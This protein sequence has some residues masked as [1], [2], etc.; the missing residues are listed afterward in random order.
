MASPYIALY[1]SDFLADIGHLGNTELGI[2]WRLLLVYYRDGRPLPFDTDRLRRLAMTFSPEE[3]RALEQVVAEFF[4]LSTEPDGSRVWRHKRA[5]TEIERAT[6][7]IDAKR[8]GAEKARAKLAE[9]RANPLISEQTSALASELISRG[10]PE[11]EPEPT[12]NTHPTGVRAPAIAESPDCPHRQVLEL[13]KSILPSMP[14]HDPELWSG[15]RAVNLRTRWRE[16]AKAKGWTDVQQG[17]AWFERLFRYIALSAFLTGR[18]SVSD[19]R[20]FLIELEWLVK[21]ANWVKVREGKYH[22]PD[23]VPHD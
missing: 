3:C 22:Q 5:D 19:K 8:S 23:E 12:L 14:Q 7:Y 20:P 9:K 21:H 15:T 17:L 2:Y 18:A 6:K 13:W 16:V 4:V 1:P 11:P 10:E